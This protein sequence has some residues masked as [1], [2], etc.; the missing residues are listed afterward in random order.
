[1]E[2]SLALKREP[3]YRKKEY[4][5]AQSK[6]IACETVCKIVHDL[7]APSLVIRTEKLDWRLRAYGFLPLF[8][9]N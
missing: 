4:I 3:K 2:A 5:F 7:E 8:N 6:Y 1:M 9:C